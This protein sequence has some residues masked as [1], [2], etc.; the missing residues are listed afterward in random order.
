MRLIAYALSIKNNKRILQIQKGIICF[1]NLKQIL[2]INLL[3]TNNQPN[4]FEGVQNQYA[5]ILIK[6]NYI[7]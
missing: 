3:I 5:D 6:K 2:C 4:F 1:I 7:G